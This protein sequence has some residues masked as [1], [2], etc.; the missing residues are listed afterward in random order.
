[1]WTPLSSALLPHFAPPPLLLFLPPPPLP[2]PLFPPPPAHTSP[3]YLTRMKTVEAAHFSPPPTNTH[4]LTPPPIPPHPP[5][6]STKIGLAE[7]R[8]Q[9][10]RWEMGSA[11]S[12]PPLPSPQHYTHFSSRGENLNPPP[13]VNTAFPRDPSLYLSSYLGSSLH[14][15]NCDSF[16]VN[17][18]NCV[19]GSCIYIYV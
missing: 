7:A 3:I 13:H 11:H 1:M 15:T 9:A 2:T 18:F 4:T 6:P 16:C 14:T 17:I 10:L 5:L 12:V 19:R 8:P